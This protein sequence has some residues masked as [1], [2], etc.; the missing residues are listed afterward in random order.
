VT[1]LGPS[2]FFAG[3]KA[4]CTYTDAP[5]RQA[6]VTTHTT[7][8]L[9]Y[10][11]IDFIQRLSQT[12]AEILAPPSHTHNYKNHPF[13]SQT[14]ISHSTLLPASD[15]SLLARILASSKPAVCI[16]ILIT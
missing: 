10:R 15:C 13:D 7:P 16:Y 4:F 8:V 14:S 2:T 6:P 5:S 3:R 11:S 1:K 12:T 9:T